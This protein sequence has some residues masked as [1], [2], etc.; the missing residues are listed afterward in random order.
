M[1]KNRLQ[2]ALLAGAGES[3]EDY[4]ENVMAI[5]DKNRKV[6]VKLMNPKILRDYS[7]MQ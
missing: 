1:T 5:L 3:A 2:Q 4:F 6:T 7:T